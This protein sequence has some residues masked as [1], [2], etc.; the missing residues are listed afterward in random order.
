MFHDAMQASRQM[1]VLRMTRGNERP[2]MPTRY[3]MLNAGIQLARCSICTTP[4]LLAQS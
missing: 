1:N 2:S 3:S 4:P